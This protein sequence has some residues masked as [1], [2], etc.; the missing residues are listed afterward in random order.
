MPRVG[1]VSV[2]HEEAEI[3]SPD[4]DIIDGSD[5]DVQDEL[6]IAIWLTIFNCGKLNEGIP[7]IDDGLN[8]PTDISDDKSRLVNPVNVAFENMADAKTSFG[9][10]TDVRLDNVAGDEPSIAP[11]TYNRFGAENDVIDVGTDCMKNE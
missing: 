10:L 11:P 8:C 4:T 3:E 2:V 9:R 5:I 6:V 7:F 1:N